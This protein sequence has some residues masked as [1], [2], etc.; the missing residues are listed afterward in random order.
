MQF[1]TITDF[2][3]PQSRPQTSIAIYGALFWGELET[4]TVSLPSG[5]LND[6]HIAE[7]LDIKLWLMDQVED[8]TFYGL[9]VRN[10]IRFITSHIAA[11]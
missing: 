5:L 7:L 8:Q 6:L 2:V 4:P 10:W 9:T 11:R 3:P 1:Q